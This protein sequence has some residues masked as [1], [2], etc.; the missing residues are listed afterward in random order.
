M[1]RPFMELWKKNA[2]RD[3]VISS[4][5]FYTNTLTEVFQTVVKT[6]IHLLIAMRGFSPQIEFLND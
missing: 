3:H 5:S 6:I 1:F 2:W 4:V